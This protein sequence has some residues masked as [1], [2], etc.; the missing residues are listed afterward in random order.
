MID[1]YTTPSCASCRKAKRWLEEHEITFQEKNLFNNKISEVE[2]RKILEKTE[3][4]FDD[5]ISTRSKIIKESNIDVNSMTVNELIAFIKENPSIL[6]RPI[7]IDDKR[8]QVGY[9]DEEIR[10]FLP[11]EYREKMMCDGTLC[12]QLERDCSYLDALKEALEITTIK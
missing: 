1:I 5:I 8:L 9:N 7:L 6:R 4:G 3:N 11:R 2:L 12:S 10:S